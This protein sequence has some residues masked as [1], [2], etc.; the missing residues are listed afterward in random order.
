MKDLESGD[1]V[2]TIFHGECGECVFCKSERTNVCE[3]NGI[4]PMKKVMAIDGRSRFWDMNGNPV[5]HFLNTSTFSEYTVMD[6][7]CVVK[8]DP[9]LMS[10]KHM[11]LLS[12][13]ISTGILLIS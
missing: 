1:Y 2:V 3:K 7:A 13:C 9:N 6:S 11:A 5:F 10:L 8:I 4:N 12:C